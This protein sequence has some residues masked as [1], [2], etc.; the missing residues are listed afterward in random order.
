LHHDVSSIPRI[1]DLWHAVSELDANDGEGGITLPE[2]KLGL[3]EDVTEP[4]RQYPS[5]STGNRA[6]N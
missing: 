5:E 3:V 6:R 2:P 1:P 4:S